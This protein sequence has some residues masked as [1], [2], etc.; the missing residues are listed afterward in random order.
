MDCKLQHFAFKN[1]LQFNHD[2]HAVAYKHT[3]PIKQENIIDIPKVIKY[4]E[5]KHMDF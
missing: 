3:V 4:V 1:K 2:L 5:P